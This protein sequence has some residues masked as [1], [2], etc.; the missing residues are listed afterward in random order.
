MRPR[1]Q[2]REVALRIGT[3]DSIFRQVFDEF[4][5]VRF[6]FCLEFSKGFGSGNFM[7][8]NGQ[9]L[10]DNLRHFLFDGFQVIGRK[11]VLTVKIIIESFSIAGPMANL[12]PGKRCWM[13]W[14][15]TWEAV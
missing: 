2:I 11:N 8:D 13:A 10:L 15:M 14:A 7:T 3:D 6:I 9:V 12:V 1:T 5:L 4:N